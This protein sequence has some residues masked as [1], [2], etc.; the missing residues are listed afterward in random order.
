MARRRRVHLEV[1]DFPAPCKTFSGWAEEPRWIARFFERADV[2]AYLR[3]HREGQV[4][5]GDTIT[6]TERP[7]HGITVRA[8]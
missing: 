1:T 8:C 3:V 6:V 2:G 7:A 5:P 4:A